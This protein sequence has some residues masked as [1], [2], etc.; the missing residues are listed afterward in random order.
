MACRYCKIDIPE[1]VCQVCKAIEAQSP[2]ICGHCRAPLDDP[3]WLGRFCHV[4]NAM[5][6]SVRS[7][8]WLSLAQFEWVH[9]NFALAR[10]KRALLGR[11]WQG[12]EPYSF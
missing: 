5:Y 1:T 6:E 2:R 7:S 9:E 12:Q 8:R 10:R 11:P 3:N 4:C